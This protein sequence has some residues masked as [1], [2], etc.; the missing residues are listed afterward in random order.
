MGFGQVLEHKP[1][2]RLDGT[3]ISLSAPQRL[4]WPLRPRRDACWKKAGRDVSAPSRGGR[5]IEEQRRGLRAA[6]AERGTRAL[7][8]DVWASERFLQTYPC[9]IFLQFE[10]CSFMFV[11][12][13]SVY[14]MST[15]PHR[16][17]DQGKAGRARASIRKP[18]A[19]ARA[20]TTA[21]PYLPSRMASGCGS[22][23]GTAALL[24]SA[25][26]TLDYFTDPFCWSAKGFKL[27][28]GAACP[29]RS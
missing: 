19:P 8:R 9:K 6:L 15:R 21:R 25:G 11:R 7:R 1:Y 10:V 3:S 2:I 4:R 22:R 13:R 17:A 18:S 29:S 24:R 28:A 26:G 27:A 5:T 23:R 16:R 14:V 12:S 20:S